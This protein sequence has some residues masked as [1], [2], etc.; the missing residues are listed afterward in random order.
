MGI[1]GLVSNSNRIF[2]IK[3]TIY[4]H[5]MALDLLILNMIINKSRTHIL[6]MNSIIWNEYFK[7]RVDE[8]VNYD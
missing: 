8:L 3:F 1:P 6:Q 7:L 2:N 5:L 4:F